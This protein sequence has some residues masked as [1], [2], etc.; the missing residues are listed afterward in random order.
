MTTFALSADSALDHVMIGGRP[1]YYRRRGAGIPLLLL[2]GWGGSSRYWRGT[3]DALSDAHDII[4][5]DLPGFGESPPL[6]GLANVH[7][8]VDT[9]VAFADRLGLTQFDINGHSFSAS[10]AVY[11]A[12]RH[13]E[14]VRR[15]VLTSFSTFRNETERRIVAK[16]HNILALWMALR[17]PWMANR[18]MFYRAVSSRFFY[19]LPA[20]DRVLRESFTD[21]LKMDKRTSLESAGSAGDP[22]INPALTQV[23]APTLIIGSRHD[24]IMP[25]AGTPMAAKLVPNSR[26]VWI[27]QCGHLPMIERPDMYHRLLSEFLG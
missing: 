11:L 18:R 21:F 23:R 14:R 7:R 2:H 19:R 25:P 4:A 15:L 13:P 20:D 17:R 6:D 16:V 12:A 8:V 1:I 9:V 10:V 27:E 3:L 24:R 26:L 5:P 22:L